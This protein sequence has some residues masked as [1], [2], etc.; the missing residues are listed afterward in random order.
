MKLCP[1]GYCT[2][3]IDR[4]AL[5]RSDDYVAGFRVYHHFEDAGE[6]HQSIPVEAT[7]K[8]SGVLGS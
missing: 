8:A 5:P 2:A 1:A 7:V 6:T 3:G 4:L